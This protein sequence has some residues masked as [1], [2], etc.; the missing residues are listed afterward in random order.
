MKTILISFVFLAKSMAQL[1]VQQQLCITEQSNCKN[2]LP[3]SCASGSFTRL[4][5][6]S[7]SHEDLIKQYDCACETAKSFATW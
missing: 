5:N 1:T 7:I 3:N 6:S 4:N 2:Q